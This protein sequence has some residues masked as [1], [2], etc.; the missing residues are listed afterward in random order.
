[1][2]ATPWSSASSRWCARRGGPAPTPRSAASAACSTS[3]R[4]ASAI[5]SSLPPTT[6][7]APRSR[8][9][10]RPAATTLIG[11]DLVAMCVNDII[12]QGAEPLFFLDYYA[13]GQAGAGCR[14]GDIVRG[15]RGGLPRSPALR[16][17]RRRDRRDAR[18]LRRVGIMTLQASAVGAAERG[19]SFCHAPASH[20]AMW[21]SACRPPVYIQT[22]SRW[23]AGSSRQAAGLAYDRPGPVRAVAPRSRRRPAG[24]DPDLCEGAAGRP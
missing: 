15:Y 16:P 3:R 6:A 5:R 9:P 18:P 23:S 1:M 8:S 11:V 10:S 17:H 2:P 21:C 7:S 13:T 19:A 12:V 14:H 22:A 24:A 20:P 4:P